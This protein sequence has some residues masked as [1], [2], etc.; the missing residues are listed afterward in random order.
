MSDYIDRE[1]RLLGLPLNEPKFKYYAYCIM[2][3]GKPCIK[4]GITIQNIRTRVR[5]YLLT[6]HRDQEKHMGT[7]MMMF[8]CEFSSMKSLKN[9]ESFIKEEFKQFP[10]N[11][12]QHGNIEQFSLGRAGIN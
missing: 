12:G 9:I 4:P 1:C 2:I 3:D 11:E 8:V 6:E 5:Q 10:L 7:F